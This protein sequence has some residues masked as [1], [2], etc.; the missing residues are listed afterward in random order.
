MRRLTILFLVILPLVLAGQQAIIIDHTCIDLDQIPDEYIDSAKANLWIGYGHTSHGSQLPQGMDALETY[1]N[2]G[3]YDWSHEGGSGELHLFEGGSSSGYLEGDC[4]T[5][6]WDTETREYLDDHPG[7]NVIIW[8]WCGQVN[9]VDLPSHYFGP[10][11]Q[12]ETDYPNVQFVYMT[13]HLEGLGP[14]GS[15]YLAN[16]QI[17]DYCI[18]NNKILYDFADIEKYSPDAD[19]NFQEYY[20]NDECDYNHPG[21]GTAN[22]ADYWLATNPGHELTQITQS[23][24]YCSHS[25]KLN[26]TKKGIASWFLW[27][28]LAG[29][30]AISPSSVFC[31][32]GDGDGFGLG[33]GASLQLG[34]GIW[35][36]L[37]STNWN[38]NT[39][40][41]HDITPGIQHNVTIPSACPNYPVVGMTMGIDT[42][43]G[44]VRCHGLD[45]QNG[46]SFDHTDALYVNGVMT[47]SGA[48]TATIGGNNSHRI[49]KRGNLSI[50][51][52]GVMILGNM[53]VAPAMADMVIYDGGEVSIHGGTLNI[54]DKLWLRSGGSLT[55][56]DGELIAHKYGIGSAIISQNPG[57]C[58]R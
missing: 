33:I 38:T 39:N 6:G 14:G 7:C 51:S 46:G 42:S 20:A 4:G 57:R 43:L 12:L 10:M 8:S 30:E 54:D 18:A 17:R 13:G 31:Y 16:Q 56:T 19:T 36:G 3:T 22:W 26:C 41:V 53:T 21:G 25:P 49:S 37:T 58:W 35:T 32:G 52:T 27:A 1:F 9:D 23:C 50:L 47:V 40:W 29:W 55:M 15:L 2:D 24:G 48:Y 28:R 44:I 11:E 45:I 5:V 34:I